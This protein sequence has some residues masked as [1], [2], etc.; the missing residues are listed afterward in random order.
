MLL[1][2]SKVNVLD[3]IERLVG[4]QAQLPN[5]PYVALWTRLQDFNPEELS[6]AINSRLAVRVALMRSTIHL[7]TAQ[8]CLD[9]RSAV[10][11]ML[12]RHLYSSP[13]W[14]AVSGMDVAAL[15]A[16][17]R[18]IVEE[19]PRTLAQLGQL[20]H[21]HWPDRDGASMAY[22]IRNFVPLVQVPPRGLW[23]GKGQAKCTTAEA[24]L[25]RPLAPTPSI[26]EIILRYLR[27]FGPA[28]IRD[29]QAWSG[30]NAALSFEKLLPRLRLFYD[31][32]DQKLFD[33]PGAPLPGPN[34]AAPVR[35][36]P[37]FDNLLLAHADRTR[38][39][40]PAGFRTAIG[41]ATVLI[42]GFASGTWK[43]VHQRGAATLFITPFER[44]SGRA[45]ADVAREGTRL[46]KFMTSG[47]K[48]RSIE[49]EE[50]ASRREYSC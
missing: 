1:K 32:R 3:A 46:L 36:L 39:N 50:L 7:V 19:E 44:L 18:A 34:T 4:L 9:L 37:E 40:H 26:E 49:F 29:F 25:G 6:H 30:L 14:R 23:G 35:F 38:I 47:A 17:G 13:W 21:K 15:V 27:A 2:R 33:V 42:D 20:L 41:Q 24:W 31:E 12:E 16:A 28:T 48:T 43:I 5:A 10:R 8:D 11:P 22:A 45:S